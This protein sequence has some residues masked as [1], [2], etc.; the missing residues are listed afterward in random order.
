MGVEFNVDADAR[1]MDSL[2]S[3]FTPSSSRSILLTL[4]DIALANVSWPDFVTNYGWQPLNLAGQD[5]FVGG[6]ELFA[7]R[8]AVQ[9]EGDVE[10][11]AHKHDDLLVVCTVARR[12]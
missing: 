5:C 7:F 2:E 4:A 9:D 12:P 8:L 10:I 3:F 6:F 11:I 1:F